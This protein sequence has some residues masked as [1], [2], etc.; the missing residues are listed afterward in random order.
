MN[1]AVLAQT[2]CGA[3][4]RRVRVAT[5]GGRDSSQHSGEG[6]QH[7]S[8]D[9][10]HKDLH[11]QRSA[12]LHALAERVHAQRPA[13]PEW[14]REAIVAFCAVEPRS[15]AELAELL[16]RAH[17]SLQDHYARPMRKESELRLLYLSHPNHPQQR[18]RAGAAVAR[19]T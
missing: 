2:R 3:G 11:A 4:H 12:A 1:A 16:G 18:Y 13:N 19:P 6:L 14:V 10:Q 17:G 7:K 8:D 15:L 5:P 9:S